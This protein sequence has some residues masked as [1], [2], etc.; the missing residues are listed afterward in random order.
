MCGDDS[1]LLPKV[2]VAKRVAIAALVFAILTIVDWAVVAGYSGSQNVLYA[3]LYYNGEDAIGDLWPMGAVAFVGGLLAIA[4]NSIATTVTEKTT[5]P[6]GAEAFVKVFIL[7]LLAG[8]LHI[9]AT[10]LVGVNFTAGFYTG[11]SNRYKYYLSIIMADLSSPLVAGTAVAAL[12]ELAAAYNAWLARSAIVAGPS[13][14]TS[15]HKTTYTSTFLWT[16]DGKEQILTVPPGAAA[17]EEHDFSYVH[18]DGG[19]RFFKATIPSQAFWG[20]G[21]AIAMNADGTASV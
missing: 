9:V 4:G 5:K 21:K 11:S 17:G 7:N 12:L 13:T 15:T 10:I 14:S 3:Y 2:K 1:D 19:T 6:E 8:I 18:A 20:K 16:V